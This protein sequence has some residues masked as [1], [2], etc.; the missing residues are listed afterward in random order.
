MTAWHISTSCGSPVA[1]CH[2]ELIA[3]IGEAVKSLCIFST[4]EFPMVIVILQLL[5]MLVFLISVMNFKT[6]QWKICGLLTASPICAIS[7]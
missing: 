1:A 3:Q 4:A 2:Q 7:S 6:Q 5:Q